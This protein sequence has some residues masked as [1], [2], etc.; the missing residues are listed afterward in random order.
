V[1]AHFVFSLR[2]R[3]SVSQITLPELNDGTGN[4]LDWPIN[5]QPGG[6]SS[7]AVRILSQLSTIT[8]IILG[9]LIAVSAGAWYLSNPAAAHKA[10]KRTTSPFSWTVWYFGG[11]TGDGPSYTDQLHRQAEDNNAELQRL[12]DDIN[13][14]LNNSWHPG[15]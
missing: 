13:N 6:D 1:A 3:T 7:G 8:P 15:R 10:A 4:E 9:V 14:R 12:R 11:K 2:G 5:E